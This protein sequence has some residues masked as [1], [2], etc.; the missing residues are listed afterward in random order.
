MEV[1]GARKLKALEDE[2]LKLKKL[3]IGQMLD[4]AM[5]KNVN[6]KNGTTRGKK[7]N[8]GSLMLRLWSEPMSGGACCTDRRHPDT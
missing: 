2:N 7:A 4:N 3:L 1:S 8:R 6:S 5:L